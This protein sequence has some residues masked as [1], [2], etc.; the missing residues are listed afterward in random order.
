MKKYCVILSVVVI[1]LLSFVSCHENSFV[2]KSLEEAETLMNEHPDSALRILQGI[3]AAQ[4]KG[5]KLQAERSL[6]LS[7]A[8]DKNFIDLTS[9]SLI[10]IAVDYYKNSKDYERLFQALYYQGRVYQNAKRYNDAMLSFTEAEQIIENVDN[11]FAKGLLYAQLGELHDRFYNFPKSLEYYT[12][13]SI[14]YHD[15]KC[16]NHVYYAK[17]SIGCVYVNLN[18]NDHAEQIVNEVLSWAKDNDRILYDVARNVLSSLYKRSGD[19]KA[20]MQLFAPEEY[21]DMPVDNSALAYYYAIG[22]NKSKALNHLNLAWQSAVDVEDT[23]RMYDYSYCVN[24]ALGDYEAALSYHEKLIHLQ[25]AIIRSAMQQPLFETQR[26]YF[27]SLAENNALQLKNNKILYASAFIITLLLI[28]LIV[29]YYRY[30]LMQKQR[31]LEDYI[32]LQRELETRISDKDNEID[33]INTHVREL[34][35]H[36]YE[37]LNKLCKI[38]YETPGSNKERAIYSKVEKE[39]ESF[40]TNSDFFDRMEQIVNDCNDNVMMK[41]RNGMPMLKP[42]EYRLFCFLC[43]GFSAKAISLFTDDIPA[44]IYVKKKRLKNKILAE[45][46]EGW[47]DILSFIE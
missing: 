27:H 25:D 7:M 45:K 40:K 4:L 10:N 38:Y 47:Q 46:P 24:K 2:S 42:R 30:Q 1:V 39:I 23:I 15:A 5:R 33:S 26:N 44:N 28:I 20:S 43:A 19:I 41:L 21:S 22:H 36:Q 12:N 17:L 18:Q 29:F 34:F 13:A 6:L 9:D 14:C 31:R 8:M 3:D 37:L 35:S 32:D 11:D 16:I